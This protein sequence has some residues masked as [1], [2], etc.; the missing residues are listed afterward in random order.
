[1]YIG[2]SIL[3]CDL[4]HIRRPKALQSKGH[5]QQAAEI[6]GHA[7]AAGWIRRKRA[8]RWE[9]VCPACL[10]READGGA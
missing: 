8:R 10:K 5:W 7:R 1:M 6:R 9:D 4:C 3:E 2:D